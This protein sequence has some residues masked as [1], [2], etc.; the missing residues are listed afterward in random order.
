MSCTPELLERDF[1]RSTSRSTPHRGEIQFFI[2]VRP[3]RLVF[4][5]YLVSVLPTPVAQA[6]SLSVSVGIVACRGDLAERGSVSRSTM[7]ATDALDLSI[8]WAAGKAPAVT[9]PRS[10]GRGFAALCCI[11][12]L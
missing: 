7:R 11:A 2:P 10:F 3:L 9:S 12:D 1:V 4:D 5:T 8:H 6:C